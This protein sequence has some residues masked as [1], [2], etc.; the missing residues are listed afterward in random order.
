MTPLP[1]GFIGDDNAPLREQVSDVPEA[2]SEPKVQPHRVADDLRGKEDWESEG[3][4]GRMWHLRRWVPLGVGTI[5]AMRGL[6]SFL[7]GDKTE[8]G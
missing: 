5:V 8:A 1:G 4:R 2:E 6:I 7:N 3:T